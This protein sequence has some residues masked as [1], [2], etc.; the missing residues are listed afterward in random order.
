MKFRQSSPTKTL[1]LLALAAAGT[2]LGNAENEKT[3][4]T[5]NEI[6]QK[7][8]AGTQVKNFAGI[9]I[10]GT[11]D[12]SKDV[13]N[14]ASTNVPEKNPAAGTPKNSAEN[15]VPVTPISPEESVPEPPKKTFPEPERKFLFEENLPD[16]SQ[17]S[18]EIAAEDLISAYERKTG[19]KLVPAEK[20]RVA[21]KIYTNS[22]RGLA[23]P[24]NLIRA[25][26]K[27]L[28]KRGFKR[29]N[30]VIVDLQERSLRLCGFLPPV[31]KANDFFWEKSPVVAL[32]T[33]KFFHEKW[34]Y[35]NT[36]PSREP[37]AALATSWEEISTERKSFLPVPL[38]FEVD[39]WINLPVAFDLPAL[40]VCGALGNATLWNVSNQKRF[41]ANPANAVQMAV[42]VATI[43]EF[44]ERFELTI[45]SLE[46]FQFIGGPI[47]NENYTASEKLIWLSANPVILDF[48]MWQRMNL[49]RKNRG[50]EMILPEPPLFVSAGKGENSLGSCVFS[51]LELVVPAE[52]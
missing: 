52:R 4:G 16:F 29:K 31:R 9:D 12:F 19:K 30:V 15:V 7:N 5:E 1:A 3:A 17:K 41:L 13:A 50:F 24:K 35:E 21:L 6:S 44:R 39:F 33:E 48:L 10:A 11:P 23:T 43:P 8:A 49:Q 27:S 32:D 22:G 42:S 46:K 45:L 51:E 28:E 25:V 40:G 14:S 26:R 36:L 38:L 37:I 34:F 20:K 18:Y 2:L 47:Y